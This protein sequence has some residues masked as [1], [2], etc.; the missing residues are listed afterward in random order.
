M[1]I[2]I[3]QKTRFLVKIENFLICLIDNKSIEEIRK[4]FPTR[5]DGAYLLSKFKNYIKS[6]YQIDIVKYC[7]IYLN[8]KWPLCPTKG[9]RTGYKISGEGLV[10][11]KFCRGGITKENCPTFKKGCE[12]LSKDRMGDKNP[13]YDKIPWNKGLDRSN[14]I[15]DQMAKNK[16]GSTASL[17]SREKQKIA[18]KNSPI[19]SRHTQ[20]HSQESK[21]KMRESTA[22]RYSEG[23]FK[24]E[25]SIHIKIRDILLKYNLVFIEEFNLKYYSLDFA[26]PE[27]KICIEAD[28]DYFH[29]NPVKY[30]NGPQ[31]KIQKR[32]F[33]RDKAKNTYLQKCKWTI[34]RFWESEINQDNF[35]DKLTCILKELN[36]LKA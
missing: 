26:F 23:K 21:D 25:T 31:D 15:I 7:E 10:I 11:S 20:K 28:G 8:I 16:E 18:R 22:K 9:I 29:V 4:E 24:R 1:N 6:K 13:M 36:L 19:K 33:G 32:N 17:E 30:P 12:R 3:D 34:V 27:F 35:E 2:L 14:L 5:N